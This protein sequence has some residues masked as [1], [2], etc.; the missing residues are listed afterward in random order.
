MR[1]SSHARFFCFF[2][3]FGLP[4]SSVDLARF[5]DFLFGASSSESLPSSS[6]SSSSSSFVTS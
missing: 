6:S 3:D 1:A 2:D 4:P 5:L